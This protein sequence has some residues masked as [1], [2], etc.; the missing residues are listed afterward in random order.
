[1]PVLTRGTTGP[2]VA[3]IQ[4]LLRRLGYLDAVDSIYGKQTFNAVRNF[5]RD[6]GLPITHSSAGKT[7]AMTLA[8]LTAQVTLSRNP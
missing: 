2:T 4:T 3:L 1:M 7:D 8:A 6:S 5:Q